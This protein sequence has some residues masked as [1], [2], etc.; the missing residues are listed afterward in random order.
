MDYLMFLRSIRSSNFKLY[1]SSIGK[2]LP[3]IFAFDHV[4]W[5][6]IHH[7]DMEMLKETNPE[8]YQEFNNNGNV[9]VKRIQN[10]FSQMRLD[11]RNQ[12]LNKDVKGLLKVL[13][14]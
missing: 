5:F 1:I 11:Q 3:W 4:R 6:S 2:V 13:K 10:R 7:H 14:F 12:Q 8:I 9:T